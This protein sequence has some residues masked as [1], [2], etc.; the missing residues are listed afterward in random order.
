MLQDVKKQQSGIKKGAN[1]FTMGF[2]KVSKFKNIVNIP[3]LQ[4]TV[5]HTV[6]DKKIMK[7]VNCPVN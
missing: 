1:R 2:I 7:S 4:I 5:R 6:N 3:Y